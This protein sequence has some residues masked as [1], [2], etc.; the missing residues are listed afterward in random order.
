MRRFSRLITAAWLLLPLCALPAPGKASAGAIQPAR[1]LPPVLSP[2]RFSQ[3]GPIRQFITTLTVTCPAGYR[4]EVELESYNHCRLTG[5][6]LL[7]IRYVLY[8]N[9]ISGAPALACDGAKSVL[10]GTGVTTFTLFGVS[11]PVI[12]QRIA[13]GSYSDTIAVYLH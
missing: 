13:S 12:D 10:T 5:P 9:A 2:M 7:S 1:C 6:G 4:F 3:S 8:A 11:E